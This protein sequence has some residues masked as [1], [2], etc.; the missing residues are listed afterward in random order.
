MGEEKLLS[1]ID[2]DISPHELLFSID[3]GTTEVRE[4][5]IACGEVGGEIEERREEEYC[6]EIVESDHTYCKVFS[7]IAHIQSAYPTITPAVLRKDKRLLEGCSSEGC[8]KG[9]SSVHQSFSISQP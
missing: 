8:R 3:G 5:A 2:D 1:S 7:F 9:W 6:S 4:F